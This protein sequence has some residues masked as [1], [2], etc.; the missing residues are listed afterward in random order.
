MKR[1]TIKDVARVAGVSY[2]TVSRALSGSPEIGEET[3]QRII[4]ISKEMGYTPN[5]IARSLVIQSTKIFGLIVGRI[6]NPFMSE[7][8]YYV[9]KH[10]RDQGYNLM[11]C[12]SGSD[13]DHEEETYRLLVGRQVDG[14]IIIPAGADSYERLKP[15]LGATPT[16]FMSENLKDLR[17]SYVT[18]DNYKGT[19]LGVDYLYSLGHRNILYFGRRLGSLTHQLRAEGYEDACKRYGLTPAFVDSHYTHSSIKKGYALAAELFRTREHLKYT[20]IM[21]STDTMA[22][23]IIK[24]ADEFGL[25]IPQDF[26]LVGFDNI[27]FS[28]LPKINL[29]TIDQPKKAMAAAAVDM[30]I[31]KINDP[32]VGYSHRIMEPTLIVRNS[33]APLQNNP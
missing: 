18:V 24:A 25:R 10:A 9:E 23:G 8:A 11:L 22:L 26:S 15:H 16:V 29:T 17:E 20:A 3:R 7:I 21:A 33:C 12:N 13:L 2:A 6:N 32:T 4:Q 5:S 30:L 19:M 1:V 31:H 27:N 14:I 28:S